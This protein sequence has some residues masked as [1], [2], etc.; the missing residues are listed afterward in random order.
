MAARIPALPT[1]RAL[2]VRRRLFMLG[3]AVLGMGAAPAWAAP[4]ALVIGQVTDLSGPTS[5]GSKENLAGAQLY[6]QSVNAKGGIAGRKL[7]LRSIDDAFDPARTRAGAETLAQDP[8]VLA[9]FMVRG[10]PNVEAIKP[11]LEAQKIALVAP[12]TG[13]MSL[14]TPVNPWIFN[15]RASYQTEAERAV[16]H[17]S[18]VGTTRIAVLYIDNSFGTDAVQ[19]ALRGLKAQGR[20]PALVAKFPPK[21]PDFKPIVAEVHARNPQAVMV[22]GASKLAATAIV[23]MRE[24]GVNAQFLTLSNNASSGFIKELGAQAHGVIV[25]QVF[26]YERAL[27]VPLVR[28]ATEASK[29]YG[30]GS[31]TPAMLEGY[32]GA[33]VLVEGLRKAGANPSRASLRDALERIEDFDL[34]GQRIS[35]SPKDHAGMKLVDLSIISSEGRFKR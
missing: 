34:G 22:I 17:L 28:D 10:T 29:T 3:L 11:V 1:E 25:S 16:E 8:A 23:Q 15:V 12:S 19:G 27:G 5:A 30:D 26:P 7:E 31:L 21:D 32:A 20:E 6:F 33:K 2:A 18:I 35:Y 14:H 24:A 13:A 9:L 4:P